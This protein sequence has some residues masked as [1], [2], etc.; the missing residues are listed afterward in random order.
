MGQRFRPDLYGTPPWQF[1][2]APAARRA[3]SD[4]RSRSE[5]PIRQRL[6]GE[7]DRAQWWSTVSSPTHSLSS[8]AHVLGQV[9]DR[10][11]PN[12]VTTPI[13][14]RSDVHSRRDRCCSRSPAHSAYRTTVQEQVQRQSIHRGLAQGGAVYQCECALPSSIPG[15]HEYR[16]GE[17]PVY[18]QRE[19]MTDGWSNSGRRGDLRVGCMRIRR[20]RET[21]SRLRASG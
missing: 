12:H 11:E 18:R 13:Q 20:M 17:W 3:G 8:P 9:V 14:A 16:R 1:R 5:S 6:E 19:W 4:G 21:V 7:L 10:V 2:E 15:W